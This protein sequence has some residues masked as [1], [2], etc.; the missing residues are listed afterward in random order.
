MVAT[1]GA[2][3]L[4]RSPAV[5]GLKTA[6][7]ST[8]ALTIGGAAIEEFETNLV[9]KPYLIKE[10]VPIPRRKLIER[11]LNFD[12]DNASVIG[13]ALGVLIAAQLR[14]PWRLLGWQRWLGAA[15][16]GAGAADLSWTFLSS[17]SLDAYEYYKHMEAESEQYTP[18][19]M[20]AAADHWEA[21]GVPLLPAAFRRYAE[22]SAKELEREEKELRSSA[23]LQ[24]MQGLSGKQP[25][26]AAPV[27]EGR[28]SQV[29]DQQLARRSRGPVSIEVVPDE[30]PA[31]EPHINEEL[32][33]TDPQ[34][35]LTATVD[36]ERV[37][38]ANTNYS[39]APKRDEAIPMLE[40]HLSRLRERRKELANEAEAL[41]HW[42]A[43][44]EAKYYNEPDSSPLKSERRRVVEFLGSVHTKIWIDVSQM[45]WMI[46][47]SQK[48]IQQVRSW[49]NKT[50]GGEIQH[51]MPPLS[52]AAA[53]TPPKRSLQ[54]FKQ[55]AKEAEGQHQTIEVMKSEAAMIIGDPTF[56]MR[57]QKI[58]NPE[59]G[60]E[61]DMKKLF[62]ENLRK[63]K[64]V[65]DKVAT[66]QRVW[67]TLVEEAE[68]RS[69]EAGRK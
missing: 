65:E 35:H 1:L 27:P 64:D 16:F 62:Q 5:W 32:D 2:I 37:P 68:K 34:P 48:N 33:R 50:S 13:A 43:R 17:R 58:V 39:W 49:D 3:C 19:V 24:A 61:E 7:Y 66:D 42:L 63:M 53:K 11:P 46:A 60:K 26:P 31:D 56:D 47:D 55:F 10:G 22:R 4:R 59:T 41:W 51:W 69:S 6:A 54:M 67:R 29:Q 18:L 28:E 57:A 36:G 23:V 52:T 9:A 12:N 44:E 21:R 25:V 40:A 8:I 38:F 15:S 30:P 20:R 45:D 14:R